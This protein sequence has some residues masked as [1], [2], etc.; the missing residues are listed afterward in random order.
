MRAHI[1]DDV[2]QQIYA[3]NT[4]PVIIPGGLV[5]LLQP[6]D[7]AVNKTLQAKLRQILESWMTSSE[8]SFTKTGRMQQGFIFL[9]QKWL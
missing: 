6:L 4:F 2:K 8:H 7:I 1:T 5:K 3:E 9:Y